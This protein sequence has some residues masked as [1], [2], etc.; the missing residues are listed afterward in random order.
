MWDWTD[1][2]MSAIKIIDSLA[3]KRIKIIYICKQCIEKVGEYHFYVYLFKSYT[4]CIV[5][6]AKDSVHDLGVLCM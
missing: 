1:L 5:K 4:E 3:N 6:K 2:K